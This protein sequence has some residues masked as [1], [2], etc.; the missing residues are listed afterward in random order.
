M[1]D[2]KPHLTL[3][4]NNAGD[5][6]VGLTEFDGDMPIRSC[7]LSGPQI[8]GMPAESVLRNR[9]ETLR[10][11]IDCTSEV[12]LHA[13]A[14]ELNEDELKT[15]QLI[16]GVQDLSSFAETCGSDDLEER[17]T[18]EVARNDLDINVDNIDFVKLLGRFQNT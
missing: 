6:F 2:N 14:S 17:L 15:V 1:P 9:F 18:D 11:L 5:V 13:A 16:D 4:R 12:L 8:D 10:R 7:V 3:E